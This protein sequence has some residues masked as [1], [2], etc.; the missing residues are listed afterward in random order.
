MPKVTVIGT[1]P[2][3]QLQD[4]STNKSQIEFIDIKGS[5]YNGKMLHLIPIEN[6]A[7]I[8]IEGFPE[9]LW[10][11]EIHSY[12]YYP[13]VESLFISKNN[14]SSDR[15]SL[16]T[17][18]K[19]FEVNKI[20][21]AERIHFF[22]NLF[23][24]C[25]LDRI[26]LSEQFSIK[27][28]EVLLKVADL[29]N[30]QSL[31]I[32]ESRDYFSA[33][34][35]TL[36]TQLIDDANAIT[37]QLYEKLKAF[38]FHYLRNENYDAMTRLLANGVDI[39]SKF[40]SHASFRFDGSPVDGPNDTALTFAVK[41][42][43]LPLTKFLLQ[44]KA[45]TEIYHQN[46]T[47]LMRA[48][49][50]H[51]TEMVQLLLQYKANPNSHLMSYGWSLTPMTTL[52]MGE[53]EEDKIRIHALMTLLFNNYCGENP[54]EL[55]ITLKGKGCSNL[56]LNLFAE[57]WKSQDCPTNQAYNQGA[58]I[59]FFKSK[60]PHDCGLKVG[61]FMDRATGNSL[62]LTTKAAASQARSEESRKIEKLR[63]YTDSP[64]RTL[65]R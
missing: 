5:I 55:N 50:Q 38:F 22:K 17:N 58:S 16:S 29:G 65:I 62:A 56:V 42:K 49:Y 61:S 39:N 34:I 46:E 52:F 35:K 14:S 36:D 30:A 53:L 1:P 12:S 6:N 3:T 2:L 44:H 37:K 13:E 47:P 28:L 23:A 9:G 20:K 57:L 19:N 32:R 11:Y 63:Q 43:N 15:V 21:L 4:W 10:L 26:D 64:Q 60:L 24:Q 25:N 54:N 45:D 51:Q 18:G 31:N 59:G 7:L 40:G 33:A 8:Y 27:E 41:T 48:C